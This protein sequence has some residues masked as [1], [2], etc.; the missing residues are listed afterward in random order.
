MEQSGTEC[1]EKSIDSSFHNLNNEAKVWY[2]FI[3]KKIMPTRNDST[4]SMDKIMLIYCIIEEIPVN[5]GEI[6]LQPILL[7][8]D[9]RE[10]L[11]L[12]LQTCLIHPQPKCQAFD[13]PQ[14]NQGDDSFQNLFQDSIFDPSAFMD[15]VLKES[16]DVTLSPMVSSKK[17]VLEKAIDD[18]L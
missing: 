18:P 1:Q 16:E 10:L 13:D 5:M 17:E 3:K 7:S 4:I 8:R 2:V 9:K 14:T 12:L 6:I 15:D 11:N